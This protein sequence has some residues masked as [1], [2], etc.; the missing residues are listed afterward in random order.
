MLILAL[1]R[2]YAYANKQ[3]NALSAMVWDGTNTVLQAKKGH[4]ELI[5]L[6]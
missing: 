6:Y 4:P 5:L 3:A 2:T 1:V